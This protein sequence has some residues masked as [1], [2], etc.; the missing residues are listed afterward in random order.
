MLTIVIIT[1][2]EEENLPRLL[3]SI[4]K[5]TVPPCEVVVSDAGSTDRTREIAKEFGAKI[6]EGG[7]PS[8]GRN[9]GAEAASGEIILFLDADVELLDE[10]FLETALNEIQARNLDVATCDVDP[11]SNA[12]IDKVLHKAYNVY[13]RLCGSFLAHAPG[14]CLFARKKTHEK[15]KGFDE[16]VIFAEDHDYVRRAVRAKQKFGFVKAAIQVSTRRLERDGRANIFIKYVLGELHL[17]FLGP[18]RH[19]KFNY[20]F[21]HKKNS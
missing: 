20:T 19:E 5:Q 10:R 16:H 17:V 18:V 8:V 6:V 21:G 9:R 15:I 12:K 2:N 3:R 14:F 7:L 13:V 1:L 11:M 4:K